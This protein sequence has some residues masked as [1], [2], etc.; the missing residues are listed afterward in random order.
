MDRI[1]SEDLNTSCCRLTEVTLLC[2]VSPLLIFADADILVA[3]DACRLWDIEVDYEPT[4]LAEKTPIL[5]LSTCHK[6]PLLSCAM[7]PPRLR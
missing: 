6:A 5:I 2:G 4:G 7:T 1:S 3:E